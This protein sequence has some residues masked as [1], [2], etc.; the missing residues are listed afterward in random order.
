MLQAK[1]I[2]VFKNWLSRKITSQGKATSIPERL[3]KLRAH[4][5]KDEEN[6][7]V[8]PIFK[9]SILHAQRIAIKNYFSEYSYQ[10]LY[11]GAKKLSVQISNICGSGASCNIAAFC[12][13]DA[14]LPVTQW[15]CWMSGQVFVPL[16]HKLPHETLKYIIYDSN[17]KLIISAKE[18]EIIAKQLTELF[19]IPLMIIDHNFMPEK[20]SSSRF[21]EKLLLTVGDNVFIEGTLNNDFYSCS[22]ALLVYNTNGVEKPK[23]CIIT[24]KN[25][26]SRIKTTSEVCNYEPTDFLLNLLPM[27]YSTYSVHSA[28]CLL[29]VGGKVTFYNDLDCKNIWNRILCINVPREDRPNILTALPS[30]YIKI[31]HEYKIFPKNPRRDEYIKNYCLNN[32]R[33]MISGPL[34]LPMNIYHYWNKLTGHKLLRYYETP[35]TG[36]IIS[37]P[38]FENKQQKWQQTSVGLQ[39]PQTSIRIANSKDEVE[40]AYKGSNFK[41]EWIENISQRLFFNEGLEPLVGELQVSGPIIFKGYL[42]QRDARMFFDNHL[43]KTGFIVKFENGVL[44]LLRHKDDIVRSVGQSVSSGEIETSLQTHLKIKDVAVVGVPVNLENLQTFCPKWLPT[45]IYLEMLQIIPDINRNSVSEIDKNLL[46]KLFLYS[47]G[48]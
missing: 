38:Y 14:L 26:Q 30:T 5:E 21:L 40:F 47:T 27:D 43:F 1:K 39:L 33:L 8:V 2:I 41:N 28:M 35:E 46:T 20:S 37:N 13:N 34:P 31:I 3:A 22:D 15:G 12:Q 17:T 18:Y 36:A 45:F 44:R 10:Q 42:N 24:H 19:D 11:I 9:K 32:F 23:G 48:S 4:F 25:L 16:L 7:Y 29:S 6:G